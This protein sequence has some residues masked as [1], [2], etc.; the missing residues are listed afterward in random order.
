MVLR[1]EGA[2]SNFE[3][4]FLAIEEPLEIRIS[5]EGSE[6]A[7]EPF[8]VTM[9]TPGDDE[10]LTM[11]LLVSEGI[12]NSA[13]EVAGMTRPE[14]PRIDEELA[15]N[16]LVVTLVPGRSRA[17]LA[18]PRMT[19]MGSAC[20][21]CGRLSIED[22]LKRDA[23]GRLDRGESAAKEGPFIEAALLATLPETLRGQQ[24]VFGRTGGLHA[25]GLFESDGRLVLLREDV[26]R[27]NAAD[28]AFG[29]FLRM[30]EPAPPIM[31]VSGRLAFE[32]VQKAVRAGVRILA[33]VSAPTSLAVELAEEAGLTLVGFLRGERFNIYA[34]PARILAAGE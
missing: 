31:L 9:R 11:G 13:E 4:D 22:V 6:I 3:P 2:R 34:H 26:G 28:K 33:A 23:A 1:R 18:K 16:V 19:V 10:D 24:A 5:E 25:A 30:G 21:V 7:P 29:A 20:G 14:D 32:I 27:H 15:R 8:L 12:V 17:G